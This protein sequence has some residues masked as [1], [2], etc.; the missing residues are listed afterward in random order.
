MQ[1][2]LRKS[3]T[4]IIFAI[5]TVVVFL[6]PLLIQL[7]SNSLMKL[8]EDVAYLIMFLI[9]IYLLSRK[10]D[11]S[12]QVNR[13]VMIFVFAFLLFTIMG[14]YYSGVS[15]IILQFREY[16][17]LLLLI[18]MLPFNK[19]DD[20]KYVWPILKIIAII[21][22]PVSIVQWFV[23]Q[24]QGDY[25]SGIMGYKNSWLLTFFLLIVFFTELMLRLK[26]NRNTFGVYFLFLLP[27]AL[28]E[29]K[30][31]LFLLPIMFFVSLLLCGKLKLK[32]VVN[33]CI[34]VLLL[35]AGWVSMYN[36]SGYS[37]SAL[38]VFSPKFIEQYMYA[39]NWQGDAGRMTKVLLALDITKNNPLLGFGLGASY[40]GVTSG[41]N[42]FIF[43]KF[44]AP[45]MLSGTRPQM[46][47]SIVD[48]GVLGSIL[49]LLVFISI[50]IKVLRVKN[51]SLEKI[52]SINSFL[53][54]TAAIPY[55]PIFFV[56]RIM[57][58]FI[59]FSFLCLRFQ[60]N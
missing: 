16:K 20:Y 10:K 47:L 23:L 5:F 58:I 6:T 54:I 52:L 37:D 26:N 53:I 42:G 34:I 33:I 7:T 40:G 56:G 36:K 14:L 25:V 39:S 55:Q 29:T 60:K 43:E 30:I 59:I 2:A 41:I 27:T 19:L 4:G 49:I 38:T 3:N 32:Y 45:E 22:V 46:V 24:N 50:F 21:C 51:L 35:G 17:Y 8:L 44:S 31:T 11:L 15:L 57:I 12:I 28:N 18:I 48:F 9:S 1:N 13:T